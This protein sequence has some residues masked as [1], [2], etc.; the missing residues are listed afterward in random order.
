MEDPKT[1]RD[2]TQTRSQTKDR[3]SDHVIFRPTQERGEGN[4][5]DCDEGSNHLQRQKAA[6]TV[7]T[8]HTTLPGN[9]TILLLSALSPTLWNN[10]F[11]NFPHLS[12]Y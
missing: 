3:E 8:G 7:S 2:K 5:Q 1:S 11:K 9:I 12:N 10:Y 6:M 4:S